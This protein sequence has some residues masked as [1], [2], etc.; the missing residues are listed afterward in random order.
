MDDRIPESISQAE[1]NRLLWLLL[2]S[3]LLGEPHNVE[4]ID[5]AITKDPEP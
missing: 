2:T 1:K 5:I 3:P 4:Y